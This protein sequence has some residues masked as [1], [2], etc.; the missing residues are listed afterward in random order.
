MGSLRSRNV[1]RVEQFPSGICWTW[2]GDIMNYAARPVSKF[3]GLMQA[4]PIWRGGGVDQ[5]L[6]LD[7][8]R[9]LAAGCWLHVFPEGR[10]IQTGQLGY[11]ELTF[12]SEDVEA[13]IGRLKWGVGKLIAHSSILPEVLPMHHRGMARVLPQNA[14]WC[15]DEHG[16]PFFNNRLKSV[17]PRVGQGVEVEF[18]EP[19]QY[20]DLIEAYEKA[21]SRLVSSLQKGSRVFFRLS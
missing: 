19:V 15:S 4:L 18:G 6:L 3:M 1:F 13:R 16:R 17:V 11:D 2:T 7:A 20:M 9:R 21:S 12:R 5:A 10:V 8:A 14:E